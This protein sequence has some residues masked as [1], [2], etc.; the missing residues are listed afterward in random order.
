MKKIICVLTLILLLIG[1]PSAFAQCIS[2]PNIC[3]ANN[4]PTCGTETYT[5]RDN[6][7]RDCPIKLVPCVESLEPNSRK[8]IIENIKKF[9][10][11]WTENEN[12]TINF[13]LNYTLAPS[14]PDDLCNAPEPVCGMMISGYD[15]FGQLCYK[16]GP[17]CPPSP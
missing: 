14:K 2:D 4:I 3:H 7:N 12:K 15:Q 11:G 13:E 8:L 10:Y 16:Q 6:C 9:T 5:G 17:K 1:L